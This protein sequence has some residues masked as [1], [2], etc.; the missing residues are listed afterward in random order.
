MASDFRVPEVKTRA[1]TVIIMIWSI[2]CQRLGMSNGQSGMQ[3][4]TLREHEKNNDMVHTRLT[5]TRAT[6]NVSPKVTSFAA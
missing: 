5:H 4:G 3:E 2:L 6:K 1:Y